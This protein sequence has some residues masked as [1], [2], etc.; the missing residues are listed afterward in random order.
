MRGD[1]GR[2]L[3][4]SALNPPRQQLLDPYRDP[5]PLSSKPLPRSLLLGRISTWTSETIELFFAGVVKQ[6]QLCPH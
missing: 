3:H 4:L 1:L 5:Q 2:G 6:L